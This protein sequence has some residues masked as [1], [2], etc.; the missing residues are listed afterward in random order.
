MP[1]TFSPFGVNQT[2][3]ALRIQLYRGWDIVKDESLH[4]PTLYHPE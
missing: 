1:R 3:S 4:Q 2:L